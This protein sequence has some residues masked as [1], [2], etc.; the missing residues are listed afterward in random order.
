MTRNRPTIKISAFLLAFLFVMAVVGVSAASASLTFTNNNVTGD[1]GATIDASGTVSIGTSQASGITIGSPSNLTTLTGSLTN[2]NVTSSLWYGTSTGALVPLYLGT[3][4]SISNSTLN[5]TSNSGSSQ[6]TTTSTGIYYNGGNVM[7]GATVTGFHCSNTSADSTALN[8]A[9]SS[10]RRVVLDPSTVCLITGITLPTNGTLD[11]NGATIH[12]SA[13]PAF[14]MSSGSQ[15]V[16]LSTISSATGGFSS[17]SYIQAAG[18]GSVNQ[19]ILEGFTID[20]TA[21]GATEIGINMAGMNVSYVDNVWIRNIETAMSF[22]GVSFYNTIDGITIRNAVTGVSSTAAG[23]TFTGGSIGTVTTCFSLAEQMTIN[24][25]Q[26][27]SFTT[28]VSAT[29][30]HISV[31]GG[32]FENTPASGTAFAPVNSARISDGGGTYF[33]VTTRCLYPQY[34]A[35]A[36]APGYVGANPGTFDAMENINGS[37]GW[38][39]LW[40]YSQSIDSSSYYGER[41][42]FGNNSGQGSVGGNQWLSQRNS[43]STLGTFFHSFWDQIGSNTPTFAFGSDNAGHFGIGVQTPVDALDLRTGGAWIGGPLQMSSGSQGGCGVYNDLTVNASNAKVISS[44]TYTFVSAD[45]GGK[46]QITGGTGW[47]TGIYGIA[48]VS[49]GAAILDSS[50]AATGTTGGIGTVNQGRIVYVAGFTDALYQC[51]SVAGALQW[52]NIT[53][54]G[55]TIIS[56]TTG[57]TGVANNASNTITF[58]GNYGLTFTLTSSTSL[59]LPTTGTLLTTVNAAPADI[60]LFTVGQIAASTTKYWS[61]SVSGASVSADL[62]SPLSGTVTDIYC[63]VTSEPGSGNQIQFTLFY[64]DSGTSMPTCTISGNTYSCHGGGYSRPIS[65]GTGINIQS[66][67]SSGAAATVARCDLR[68]TGAS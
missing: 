11:L 36:D 35:I 66:I 49:G 61:I 62:P 27:E 34:C 18:S 5:A 28:G 45:V 64:G 59:T 8:A 2:P 42:N 54:G 40:Y 51:E 19:V 26:C 63:V 9:L 53:S 16:G 56:P 50:P 43:V 55:G 65:Q 1:N 13:L 4:L 57:G 52:V 17:G 48:S 60:P 39:S 25:V 33:A 22:T 21:P 29:V 20:N 41:G 44:A 3:N 7:I 10:Y 37:L 46:L 6:W 24:G 67:S 32:R 14:Q 58:S 12:V 23:N 30:G 15:L 31:V 38:D 47:T 68:V